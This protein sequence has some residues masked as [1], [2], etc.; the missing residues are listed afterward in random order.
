MKPTTIEKVFNL[1]DKTLFKM[2]CKT[3]EEREAMKK[4]LIATL[5]ML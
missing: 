4:Y 5:A 2:I 3:E 1:M